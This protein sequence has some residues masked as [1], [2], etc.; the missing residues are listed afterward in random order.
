[1]SALAKQLDP[2]T[3][4]VVREVHWSAHVLELLRE[5]R[6]CAAAGDDAFRTEAAMWP[7]HQETHHA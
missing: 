2:M 5:A 4:P 1:V 7:L 6:E 3:G